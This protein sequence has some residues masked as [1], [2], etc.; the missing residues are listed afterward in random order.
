[1]KQISGD[2]QPK[3]VDDTKVR[4]IEPGY[5]TLPWFLILL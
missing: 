3:V 2:I 4:Q 5:D 1:M